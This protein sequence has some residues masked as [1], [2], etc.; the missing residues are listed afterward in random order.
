MRLAHNERPTLDCIPIAEVELNLQC[1]DELIPILRALQHL[2]GNKIVLHSVLELIAKDVNGNSSAKLGRPGLSYWEIVVLAAVR[3]G[4]KLNYDKLQ[5]L[6]ENHRKLRQIMGIGNWDD[7]KRFDWRHIQDN[8]TW[9]RPETIKAINDCIVAEGH[10]QVPEA[11]EKVRGDAFVVETN[12]HYPTESSLLLD[13]FR[14]IIPLAFALSALLG[15]GGWRQRKHLLARV[16]AF[17]VAIA[18]VVRSKGKDKSDASNIC[19]SP[20]WS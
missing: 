19:T 11:I 12:I 2:Y 5:D 4:C 20:C 9:L 18:K 15:L 7:G 17:A 13:G 3:L 1:R 16:Q 14:K 10:R 8:I 6:A